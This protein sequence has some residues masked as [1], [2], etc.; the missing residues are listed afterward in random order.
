MKIQINKKSDVECYGNE[1]GDAVE[2]E[3]EENGT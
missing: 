2:M 1:T 3:E